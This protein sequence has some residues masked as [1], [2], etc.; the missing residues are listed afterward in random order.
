M[1]RFFLFGE[2]RFSCGKFDFFMLLAMGLSLFFSFFGN[3]LFSFSFFG[4]T[5][6]FYRAILVIC[7]LLCGVRLCVSFIG[8]R[9]IPKYSGLILIWMFWSLFQ[10]AY[11]ANQLASW[12]YLIILGSVFFVSLLSDYL[13][14]SKEALLYICLFLSFGILLNLLFGCVETFTGHYFS[15][16]VYSNSDSL[17]YPSKFYTNVFHNFIP[18]SFFGNP[19]N[20]GLFCFVSLFVLSVLFFITNSKIIKGYSLFVIFLDLFIEV[21]T[22]SRSAMISSALFILLIFLFFSFSKF[23]NKYFWV[24]FGFSLVS[25][26]IICLLYANGFLGVPDEGILIRLH[27]ISDGIDVLFS[28]TFGF[29][30]GLGQA[31]I[32]MAPYSNTDG[33]VNLHSFFLEILVVGG[34]PIFLVIIAFYLLNI[35]EFLFDSSE[36]GLSKNSRYLFLSCASF[37]V[38]FIVAS[39]GPSHS[40]D[41]DFVWTGFIVVFLVQKIYSPHWI[42]SLDSRYYSWRGGKRQIEI[43]I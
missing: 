5:I 10:L 31:E 2:K 21:C 3:A 41:W 4:I 13:C 22:D 14:R 40:L 34:L 12:R 15:Y 26:V 29:G 16:E 32:Y 23:F 37:L 25:G 1:K 42:P 35:K 8:K 39:F 38:S 33:I 7:F 24:L 6:S 11:S 36:T 20:F 28:K 43:S 17:R 19:N 9:Y 27:L 18:L 30:V